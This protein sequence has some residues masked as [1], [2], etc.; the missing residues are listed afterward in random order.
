MYTLEVYTWE[1]T[2]SHA[3]SYLNIEGPKKCGFQLEIDMRPCKFRGNKNIE[4]NW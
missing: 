4:E 1:L 2:M 3:F